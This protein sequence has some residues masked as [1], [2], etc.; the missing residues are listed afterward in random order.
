MA[1]PSLLL[2]VRTP[3]GI[4]FEAPVRSLRVPTDTGQVGLRPRA[5]RRRS[6]GGRAR[7]GPAASLRGAAG[8]LLRCDRRRPCWR[9][10]PWR[11]CP[12]SAPTRA[13]L[14]GREADLGCAGCCNGSSGLLHELRQAAPRA[15]DGRPGPPLARPRRRAP[16]AARTVRDLLPALALRARHSRLVDR[17]AGGGRRTVHRLDLH[18]ESGVRFTLM[19]LVAGVIVVADHWRAVREHL[20]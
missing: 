4:A 15:R 19:L 14:R 9:P 2:R 17:G 10:S 18:W 11:W 7:A 3:Q 16:R 5:E 13:A 8:G 1:E 6:M 20:S 12:R